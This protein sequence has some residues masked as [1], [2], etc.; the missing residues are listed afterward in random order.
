MKAIILAGGMGTRLRTVIG[1]EIPKCMAPINGKPFIE[2]I[3]NNMRTQ[4]INDITLSLYY[5]AEVVTKY[6]G[7]SVKYKI[8]REPL[9]TGGAIRNCISGK[10]SV[11]VT[12]GDTLSPISY[13][14]MFAKT[15]H[16]PLTIAATPDEISAG[17]YVLRP[18]IFQGFD[19]GYLSFERDVIPKTFSSFYYI[20]WF[21]DIGTPEGYKKAQ[22]IMH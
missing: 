19:D 7:D 20:P 13:V 11:I 5:K 12:N 8:E 6:F 2:Y 21:L 16:N 4:G 14:D 18:E 15:D 17:I 10:N 22:E 9:E 3:I 1:D